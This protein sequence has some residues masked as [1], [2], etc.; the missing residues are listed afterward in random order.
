MPT[1]LASRALTALITIG[2]PATTAAATIATSPGRVEA[3][4]RSARKDR[5]ISSPDTVGT[6]H[7]PDRSPATWLAR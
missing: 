4:S 2:V 5:T 3:A 6:V 7:R 1:T